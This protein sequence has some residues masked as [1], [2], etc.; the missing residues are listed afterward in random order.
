MRD[1]VHNARL[2][3]IEWETLCAEMANSINNLPV[4]IGN[5]TSELENLDLITPNRLRLSRNNSRSPIGVV[6][7]TDRFDRILQ[8]NSD[9]FNAWWEAW[10]TSAVPKLVPQPKWFRNDE[11][12]KVGDVVLFKRTEGSLAGEYK[13]GMVDEVH[14][15]PDD[16]IRSV[17]LR[18]KNAS[19]E[20]ERKTVRA[21]RSLVI[22]HRID[23]IN[24]MEELGKTTF[25]DVIPL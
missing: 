2:S 4:V 23:E 10:L 12:I 24:I 1:S 6:E 20:I 11:D 7:L 21:V 9:I 16:R 15:G 8:I 22:V 3:T 13:Y 5:E 17:V 25:T 19:E 14:R 18:Y